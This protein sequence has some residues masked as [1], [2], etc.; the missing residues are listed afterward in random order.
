MKQQLNKEKGFHKM[1]KNI[2]V[3]YLFCK[4]HQS[5][6]KLV[7]LKPV[8]IFMQVNILLQRIP[9]SFYWRYGLRN[10]VQCTQIIHT[11]VMYD[12]AYVEQEWRFEFSLLVFLWYPHN[13]GLG[14]FGLETCLEICGRSAF[15]FSLWKNVVTLPYMCSFYMYTAFTLYIYIY[16]R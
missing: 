7:L 12:L 8:R 3:Y 15:D 6:W 10:S 16:V 11:R 13:V 2:I 5:F 14:H 4:I 9:E 1:W